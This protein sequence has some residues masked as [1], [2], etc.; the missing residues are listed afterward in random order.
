MSKKGRPNLEEILRLGAEGL[1]DVD[2][3]ERWLQFKE[4]WSVEDRTRWQNLLGRMHRKPDGTFE[5]KP[6]L[7]QLEKQWSRDLLH[8]AEELDLC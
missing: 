8:R 6:P 7:S 1:I 4:Q 3:F 2:H 5:L